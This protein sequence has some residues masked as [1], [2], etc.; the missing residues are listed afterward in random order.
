MQLRNNLANLQAWAAG[1]S[2]PVQLDAQAKA[3]ELKGQID[4]ILN[5]FNSELDTGVANT[6]PTT[7]DQRRSTAADL[8][9]QGTAASSPFDFTSQV[10]AA[11]Q[12]QPVSGELPI[13]TTPRKKTT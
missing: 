10:P 5:P 13:F 1:Q 6:K 2:L 4:S 9:Q 7:T 11:F 3:N 8:A 12:G